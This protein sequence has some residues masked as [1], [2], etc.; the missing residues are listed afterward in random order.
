MGAWDIGA[1]FNY[2][3]GKPMRQSMNEYPLVKLLMIADQK[4]ELYEVLNP[5]RVIIK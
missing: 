1:H 4:A 2:P 5:T 3:T